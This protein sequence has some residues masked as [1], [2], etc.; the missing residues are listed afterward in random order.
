MRRWYDPYNMFT[1]LILLFDLFILSWIS[2]KLFRKQPLEVRVFFWPALLIKLTAGLIV[3]Y[4]YFNHYQEGD[5]ITY[6]QDGKTIAAT[7][8]KDPGMVLRF[9]MEDQTESR[10]ITGLVNSKP[11]SLFFV[12][13]CS[14]LAILSAGNYWMMSGIISFISFLGV[15][16]LFRKILYFFPSSTGSASV[17]FLF[18]P[19]VV[20]WSAG[21]IKE[22]LGLGSIFF[23]AGMFLSFY[24]RKKIHF[25]EWIMGLI[26]LGIGW[27]LKY[28]WVGLLLPVA[29]TTGLVV[30][31]VRLRPALGRFDLI[32]WPGLFV[33]LLFAATSVHPNFYPNR[34]FEVIWQNNQE[35]MMLTKVNNAVHYQDLQPTFQSILFNAPQALIAGMF[36]PF[37]WEAHDFLSLAA[38]FENF[39]VL[40][41]VLIALTSMHRLFKAPHRLLSLSVMVYTILLA[42]FLA[43]STPNFGT[44]S[45]YK[46]GFLPFLVFLILNKNPIFDRL[47]RVLKSR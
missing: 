16:Y 36:R 38:A 11:R 39:I 1:V 27:N 22:S 32:I 31:A 29:L 3:G 23:L 40:I 37:V 45:R 21:I 13:I 24:N 12:K 10:P 19:S 46:I 34:F 44:L 18:F 41:L 43:L 6:W 20:F 5:T 2:Y 42:I 4:I 9:M 30:K 28:Y 8:T 33:I 15:W 47:K 35:F 25:W 14:V 7:M 17:A 26:C